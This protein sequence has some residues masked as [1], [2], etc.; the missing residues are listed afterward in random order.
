MII[1]DSGYNNLNNNDNN[2]NNNSK[3]NTSIKSKILCVYRSI[4]SVLL[5]YNAD[6]KLCDNEGKTAYDYTKNQQV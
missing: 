5:E 4:I 3:S 2:K 1:I 6:I